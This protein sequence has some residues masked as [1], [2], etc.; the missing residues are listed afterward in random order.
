M[1]VNQ[2][3]VEMS[4]NFCPVCGAKGKIV[5]K[6]T[7]NFERDRVSVE[8]IFKMIPTEWNDSVG[9]SKMD[10]AVALAEEFI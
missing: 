2:K 7:M 3:G 8:R 10:L 1:L 5:G 4:K 6:T 9:T